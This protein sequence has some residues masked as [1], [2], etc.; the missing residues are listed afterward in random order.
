MNINPP[1]IP[2]DNPSWMVIAIAALAAALTRSAFSDP[3]QYEVLV[4]E[5]PDYATGVSPWGIND[6]AQIVGSYNVYGGGVDKPF[7]WDRGEFIPLELPPDYMQAH[8]ADINDIGQI[9]GTMGWCIAPGR[10]FLYDE[11]EFMNLGVLEGANASTATAI[12][13]SG[14]IVGYS[15]DMNDGDP[16]LQAY[17][18]QDGI[19]TNLASHFPMPESLA[20]DINEAG[21]ITGGTGESIGND[22]TAFIWREGLVQQLGPIPGGFTSEGYAINNRGEVAGRGKVYTEGPRGSAYHGFLYCDGEMIDIG[23]VQG[24]RGCRV[25][26]MNDRRQI[27]GY[28]DEWPDGPGLWAFLW[29]DG[30]MY[31]LD[32][33]VPPELELDLEWGYAIN[34]AGQITARGYASVDSVTVLLSPVNPWPAD[35]N[36]DGVVDINDL[37]FVL[38]HWG[39]CPDEP[40][41]CPADVNGD[42]TVDIDDIFAVISDWG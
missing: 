18:W 41:M 2:R 35:V 11:G 36:W 13:D 29:Q 9:V 10:G 19:M 8:C 37:F 26:A 12:N 5:V 25:R 16:P 28:C 6:K 22:S 38:T 23:L 15:A 31:S 40:Q 20:R 1:R 14:Q 33:L 17:V 3:P 42:A 30:T 4:L 32:D 27:V 7:L 24:A 39:L 34:N 21:Q